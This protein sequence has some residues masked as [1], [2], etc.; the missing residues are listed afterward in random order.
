[1][2]N[3]ALLAKDLAAEK[4]L[5]V[6]IE[7]LSATTAAAGLGLVVLAAARA[8]EAGAGLAEVSML[9][10]RL[11][12]RVYLFASLDTLY[13][14][15]KGGRI[16]K[17]AQLAESVFQ[18]KPVFTVNG[19]DAHTVALPRTMEN[20]MRRILRLMAV[21]VRPGKAL[22][23]AVMHA[24]ALERAEKLRAQIVSRF[25]PVEIFITEFTPV[26]GV[27]TGPGV[28]GAAFYSEE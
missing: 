17:V 24:D 26:M 6:K 10:Q 1:M 20:A 9:A 28:I 5:G 22:H 13:Y 19:G 8:A 18:I 4:L 25:K 7:V 14:L 15:I 27:H 23:V 2:Y 16:P 12:D 11:M 21:R 3:A